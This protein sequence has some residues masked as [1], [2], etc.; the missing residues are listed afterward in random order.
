MF[1]TSR[2]RLT[3]SIVVAILLMPLA[4]LADS[5]TINNY[6]LLISVGNAPGASA[7]PAPSATLPL[8]ST[9]SSQ[10]AYLMNNYRFATSQ[11]YFY[12]YDSALPAYYWYA[13]LNA[14]SIGQPVPTNDIPCDGT[15]SLNLG[16]T[17]NAI[18]QRSG[19]AYS[20]DYT[21]DQFI[22]TQFPRLTGKR[23][24]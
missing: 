13:L 7:T 15:S 3:G 8:A 24:L 5:T 14:S 11:A 9:L 4:A 18:P 2:G 17:C 12:A 1:P 20:S 21:V 22:Q 6:T 10:S 19:V 23:I 16:P